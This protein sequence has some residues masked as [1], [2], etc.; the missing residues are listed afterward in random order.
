VKLFYT[1]RRGRPFRV[2]WLLEEAGVQYEAVAVE[3]E[4]RD[5]AEHR[6]RQPLGRVPA[7]ELDDGTTLFDSTAIVLQL[8]DMYPDAGL[9]G[10]LGSQE[11]ADAYAWALT[12]MTELEGPAIRWL[13]AKDADARARHDE[14]AG[15][16]ADALGDREFLVGDSLSVADIVVGGVVTLGELAGLMGSDGPARLSDYLAALRA[17]PAFQTA[18]E[19]VAAVIPREAPAA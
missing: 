19:R 17:R 16:I 13:Q 4:Q 18:L 6:A 7:L 8:A 9:V 11:R 14:V 12:A 1:T 3:G 15:I 5:S 2:A 10:P